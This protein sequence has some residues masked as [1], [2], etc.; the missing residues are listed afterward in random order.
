MLYEVITLDYWAR[1][2]G[3]QIIGTGD[4][5]HPGWLAEL[6]E[7]LE[8]AEEG[9][10]RL[11]ESFLAVPEAEAFPAPA[12]EVRF[13]LTGE[14]SNI[15]TKDGRVRKVHNLVCLPDF[16]TADMLQNRLD[17]IV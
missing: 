4:L 3:I 13:M 16:A 15:Y 2:K 9:L 1:I 12:G 10:F 14:I 8:P 17:K 11:K 6:Q 7:K 5:T